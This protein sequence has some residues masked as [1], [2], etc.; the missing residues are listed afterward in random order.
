MPGTICN[1]IQSLELEVNKI[2]N[3][4]WQLHKNH[5]KF[6]KYFVRRKMGKQQ[7]V[8]LTFYLITKRQIF[9]KKQ[10]K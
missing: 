4:K 3:N 10:K 2:L 7:S 6:K 8:Q 1:D 9:L 5:K